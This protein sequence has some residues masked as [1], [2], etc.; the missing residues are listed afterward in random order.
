MPTTPTAAAYAAF[1]VAFLLPALA[2]ALWVQRDARRHG[3]ERATAWGV[4]MLLAAPLL[5]VAF[6]VY[7]LARPDSV[8]VTPPERIDRVLR[9]VAVASVVA[10]AVVAVASPPDPFTQSYAIAVALPVL[11]VLGV[12]LAYRDVMS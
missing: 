3:S 5:P 1:L 6:V 7:V 12:L 11:V 2:T 8:P 4:G 9:N 10:V